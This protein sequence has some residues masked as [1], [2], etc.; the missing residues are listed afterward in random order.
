MQVSAEIRWFWRDRA[1]SGLEDW[2][3]DRDVHGCTAG[4][5]ETRTDEYLRDPGQTELGLKLRGT[6]PG[7]EATSVEVKGLVAVTWDG[8][9]VA[10]FRG[11][12]EIWT[13]VSTPALK[14][15]ST[16]RVEKERWLRKFDTSG[17]AVVEVP[18]GTRS[19]PVEEDRPLPGS[20]CNVEL[21]RLAVAGSVWWTLGFESFGMLP[22]VEN[23]LRAAATLLATRSPTLEHGLRA[24]YPVW[25]AHLPLDPST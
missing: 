8:L 3:K 5:P 22:T 20:G 19:K 16:V 1:P 12:I 6:R 14:L 15:P 18:L 10:P 23:S 4:G 21:T 11:P 2:F 9:T 25:L 7:V 24:S 17:A 13:K